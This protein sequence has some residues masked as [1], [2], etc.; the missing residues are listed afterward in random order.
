MMFLHLH[1]TPEPVDTVRSGLPSVVNHVLNRAIAKSRDDR[2][3]S[4]GEL[5]TALRDALSGKGNP[6]PFRSPKRSG[7][8]DRY[9]STTEIAAAKSAE[10]EQPPAPENKSR[11]SPALIVVGL[12]AVVAI[13]VV[14]IVLLNGQTNTPTPTPTAVIAA[15]GSR[16]DAHGIKQVLVPE[17]CFMMGSDPAT[18]P[19]TDE[20][21]IPEHQVCVSAVWMDVYEVTN[22]A[23]QAFVDAGGYSDAQWWSTDGWQWVQTNGFAGPENSP[24]NFRDPKQPRVNLSW[25]ESDAYA[26][27]RGGRLP[28]EAEWEYAARGAQERLYAWGDGYQLGYTVINEI[29]RGGASP[30]TPADVGSKPT[31]RSWSGLYD[32]AGNACEWVNDWYAPYSADSEQDPTGTESGDQRVIRGGSYISSP[33]TARLVVR[34][35]RDPG[36]R[37]RTCGVRVASAS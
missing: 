13:V 9:Q 18:D 6:K 27:W 20:S 28:T 16:P 29:S 33:T 1:G 10:A 21:E 34:T 36:S 3:A 35:Q 26:R 30:T 2:F 22:E 7:E 5:F 8:S 23:Y 25:Y 32:M 17:G 15:D 19:D 11:R 4:A 14:G 12:I 31:D 24:E 37:A